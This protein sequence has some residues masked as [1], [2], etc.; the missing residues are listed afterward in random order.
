M[1]GIYDRLVEIFE[2]EEE[3]QA[4]ARLVLEALRERRPEVLEANIPLVHWEAAFD[5]L[6]LSVDEA[7]A[8][9]VEERRQLWR[10]M[11]RELEELGCEL[12]RLGDNEDRWRIEGPSVCVEVDLLDGEITGLD[13]G[14]NARFEDLVRDIGQMER[15]NERSRAEKA[16]RDAL[17]EHHD[18]SRELKAW[19]PRNGNGPIIR[20]GGRV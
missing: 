7:D 2:A 13:Y 6:L 15:S 5:A 3:P 16:R 1:G 12:W 10:G 19:V 18:W 20:G 11:R 4:M 8:A 14:P 17:R 9:V